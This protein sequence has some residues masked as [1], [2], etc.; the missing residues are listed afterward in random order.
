MIRYTLHV[1]ELLNDGTPVPDRTFDEV[2]QYILSVS[3]GYTLIHAAGGWRADT[4]VVTTEPVRLY[5][6]DAY[7]ELTSLRHFARMLAQ[8]LSQEAIYLTTQTVEVE[9]VAP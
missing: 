5:V 9:L 8:R 2:E 6:I 3:D 4:G 1:P 7:V